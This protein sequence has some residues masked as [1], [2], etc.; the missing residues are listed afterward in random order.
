MDTPR[1]VRNVAFNQANLVVAVAIG[2]FMSPFIVRQLGDTG[3]GYWTLVVTVTAYFGYFDLGIQSGINHY[4]T[5]HL[6]DGDAR[7][8]NDKFNSALNVLLGIGALGLAASAVLAAVMPDLLRIPAPDQDAVRTALLLVGVVT[9]AKF[10]LSAFQAVLIGAQR[11]DLTSGTAL[12]VR[13]I[14]AALVFYA[15]AA[16]QHLLVLAVIVAATQLLEGLVLL[17]FALREVPQLRLRWPYFGWPGFRELIDYGAFNFVINIAAQFGAGFGTVVVARHI[18]AAAVTFYTISL[19]VVPYM[20]SVIAA[21]CL[22]LLQIFIPLDVRGDIGALRTLFLKGSR[23][24]GALTCLMSANLL[25]VGP[26][27]LGRWMGPKYLEAHPYGS[28]GVVLIVLTLASA[29]ALFANVAEMVLFSRRKNRI[30]AAVI[31]AET[32]AIVALSLLFVRTWG[33]IGVALAVLLPAIVARGFGL[34]ALA[35]Y[36][37]QAKF[38]TFLR[39]AV[40]PNLL[41]LGAVC[42]IGL[43]VMRVAPPG[44]YPSILLWFAGVSALHAALALTFIIERDDLRVLAHTLV[45]AGRRLLGSAPADR[46]P[47]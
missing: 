39:Q 36:Y 8:L 22:P 16:Q 11:Y 46:A 4:V 29:V 21:L 7:E 41:V 23:Y 28:S 20:A 2:L 30:F 5:R 18:D 34:N 12:V 35:A 10:P 15:L 6:A 1:Y 47:H 44:G 25:L 37:A 26:A 40:W 33:I 13:I 38:G 45:R 17:V 9:A 19:D 42:A 3:N 43:L 31:V 32:I 14:N 24:L 27:F